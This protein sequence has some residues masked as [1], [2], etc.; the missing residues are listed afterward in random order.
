MHKFSKK[1]YL[2][3]GAAAVIVASGAGVAFAYW[4]STGTG[5]GTATTDSSHST[6]TVNQISVP[7]DMA[8]GVAPGAVT[9]SVT[10][11]SGTQSAYVSNVVISIES[12]S[13]AAVNGYT[14]SAL[15]YDLTQ[16]TWAPV[17]LEHGATSA[18]NNT[19][20]LGF[21]NLAAQNQ[22]SCQGAVVHLHYAAS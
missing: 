2:A 22:D 12:V 21:H 7:T 3:A 14:C 11:N 17:E 9:F 5:S 8:P 20:T 4:T 6:T 1:Q 18:T 15:D 13:A 16:P 19:A 10:N